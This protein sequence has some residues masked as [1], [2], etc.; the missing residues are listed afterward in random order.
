MNCGVSRNELDP[1]ELDHASAT[2][3][4]RSGCEGSPLKLILNALWQAYDFKL[5]DLRT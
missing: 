2:T 3:T 5:R 4:I 1:A